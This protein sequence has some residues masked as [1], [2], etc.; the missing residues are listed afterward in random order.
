[1]TCADIRQMRPMSIASTI[2][3]DVR[4]LGGTPSSQSPENFV[5]ASV[6][7]DDDA[8]LQL[9]L[10]MSLADESNAPAENEESVQFLLSRKDYINYI[11]QR[12]LDLS[13]ELL[14]SNEANTFSHPSPV[15]QLALNIILDTNSDELRLERAKLMSRCIS[16]RL[17]TLIGISP[18]LD[19]SEAHRAK[20]NIIILLRS[21]STLLLGKEDSHV[22]SSSGKE[23]D[24]STSK[25]TEAEVSPKNKDKTDPRFVCDVHG[26]P[27]VRRRCSHGVHKDRR[28]YLCGMERRQR[29]KYFKWADMEDSTTKGSIQ[30]TPSTPA[31]SREF[32]DLQSY[33]CKLFTEPSSAGSKPLQAQLCEMLQFSY[34]ADML[35]GCTSVNG[36]CHTNEKSPT[37]SFPLESL[38][39]E[40]EI[41]EDWSDGVFKSQEKRGWCFDA[42]ILDKGDMDV[43]GLERVERSP[44]GVEASLVNGSLDLLAFVASNSLWQAKSNAKL[45]PW[46][47]SWFSL[48]CEMIGSSASAHLRV[49][50]KRMLKR[51]CGGRHNYH[52]VRDHW[53]FKTQLRNLIRKCDG[54]LQAAIDVKEKARRCGSTWKYGEGVT[55]GSLSVGGLIGTGNLVSEDSISICD[56]E[57]VKEMLDQLIEVTETRGENWRKFCAMSE[58]PQNS[59]NTSPLT[60]SA[61]GITGIRSMLECPP[62]TCLF[63]MGCALS[64]SNQVKMLK[65]I[66]IALTTGDS[67]KLVASTGESSTHR[68]QEEAGGVLST[69][70][71]GGTDNDTSSNKVVP[72]DVYDTKKMPEEWLLKDQLGLS[73]DE[74]HAF[75]IEL[76]LRG[77][78]PEL[79]VIASQ[80]VTKLFHNTS[81]SDLGNLLLRFM[82]KPLQEICSLGCAS[83]EFLKLLKNLVV[84]VGASTP[85]SFGTVAQIATQCFVTQ[86]KAI[87]KDINGLLPNQSDMLEKGGS[88]LEQLTPKLFDLIECAH[89]HRQK[90]CDSCEDESSRAGKTS[91]LVSSKESTGVERASSSSGGAGSGSGKLDSSIAWLPGQIKPYTKSR[92]DN[93]TENMVSTEFAAYA[94]LK[95]RHAVSEISLLI[96]EPRG[97]LVKTIDILFTPGQVDDVNELKGQEYSVLWQKCGTLSLQR[98]SSRATCKLKKPIIAANLKFAYAQFWEKLGGSRSSDGGLMLHCPRCT[99]VVNNAHGVCGHCGEVAFQCRKCRH[100]NYDRL[101]AFLCVECNYCA[102]GSFS[103]EVTS[104][105]ASNAVAITDEEGLDRTIR[106]LR[107]SS[108]RL[109]EVRNTLRKKLLIV[110]AS[111]RKRARGDWGTLESI[112]NSGPPPKRALLDEKCSNVDGRGDERGEGAGIDVSAKRRAQGSRKMS[113]ANKARTLLSLARQ[114]RSEASG[115]SGNDR[116]ARMDLSL[117]QDLLNGGGGSGFDYLDEGDSDIF[118][119]LNSRGEGSSLNFE[120]GP[121]P[122]SRLVANIQARVRSSAL[123]GDRTGLEARLLS[124]GLADADGDQDDDGEGDE[125]GGEEGN[126]IRRSNQSA[127]KS[128]VETCELLHQQMREAEKE[129]HELQTRITAWEC[130]NN[131]A[132]GDKGSLK[133]LVSFPRFVPSVCS[134][135]SG[136]LTLHLLVVV[137]TVFDADFENTESALTVDF[138]RS[139]FEEPQTMTTQLFDLK[140][141][142]IIT[143]ALNSKRGASLVLDELKRRL[144]FSHDRQSA[145]ILGKLIESDFSLADEYVAFALKVL[146]R[147]Q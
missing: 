142:A 72:F 118:G 64:G 106:L 100:I 138:V 52:R 29:C 84:N 101:D 81:P 36:G 145:E 85:I 9:A 136:A 69:G 98:G 25:D 70:T 28:F 144:D 103:F 22:E 110:V 63:W 128:Y 73:I 2:I 57:L 48:L 108:R 97:R 80:V 112:V 125:E 96:S 10:R 65:L 133:S 83:I 59:G 67:S 19:K 13:D 46:S 14:S 79:R 16:R 66:D 60:S 130:L 75:T 39:S 82:D 86:M 94:Q 93:L 121:D 27:A 99:R 37:D 40:E 111:K 77:K 61:M 89:C 105:L 132:L 107:A 104:G 54:P 3:E 88:E 123:A 135:C 102:S 18:Q 17:E 68:V 47:S 21:L 116:T 114:L 51:L 34:K 5:D 23:A 42:G 62:I 33:M 41:V 76:V 11:L 78:T 38:R 1:M 4:R 56:E 120:S 137:M 140:R 30:T 90:E 127:K 147:G 119:I 20:C 122:L 43:S 58:I 92:L 134:I 141:L 8:V 71:D 50:A 124:S 143:L 74:I 146:D 12:T 131:D 15:I 87:S 113:S 126:G 24:E 49:Q 117:R 7:G 44:R 53:Q 32:T 129:C 31:A 45:P 139:L 6:E 91:D 95:S 55:W 35:E 26:V 115:S 109:G